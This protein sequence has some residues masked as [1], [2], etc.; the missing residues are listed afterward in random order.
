[1]R[2]S[3]VRYQLRHR[4]QTEPARRALQRVVVRAHD[5]GAHLDPAF[6]TFQHSLHAGDRVLRLGLDVEQGRGVP[7][8][9]VGPQAQEHVGE[10][11]HAD[12][13]EGLGAVGPGL[14]QRASAQAGD[15]DRRQ[16]LHRLEAGGADQHVDGAFLAVGGHDAAFGDALDAVGDQ[17]HVGLAHRRVEVAR[18]D[19]PLAAQRVGR[20]ELFAQRRIGQLAVAVRGGRLEH[21]LARHRAF[22]KGAP[23]P[24][25]HLRPAP[26][27]G[28][29]VGRE[30]RQQVVEPV[31]RAVQ[32]RQHPV[33]GALEH[34]QPPRLRGDRRDQLRGGGAG[35]DHGDAVPG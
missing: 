18:I 27:H 30:V 15:G 26:A 29:G 33:G 7:G 16:Q 22:V 17:F 35:A 8:G 34:M 21:A 25:E 1:M 6:P 24:F 28:A 31:V 10:A 14:A 19:E 2:P 23:A 5:L 11:R 9:G 20:G 32:S 3:C 4:L 12:A 13:V